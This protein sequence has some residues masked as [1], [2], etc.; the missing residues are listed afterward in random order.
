MC[1]VS[2]GFD[3]AGHF[4]EVRRIVRDGSV[5]ALPAGLSLGLTLFLGGYPRIVGPQVVGDVNDGSWSVVMDVA[6]PPFAIH[7][8]IG[9]TKGRHHSFDLSSFTLVPARQEQRIE[10]E[11]EIGFGMTPYP[12]DYRTPGMVEAQSILQG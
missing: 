12:G 9:G 5:E 1:S 6:L 8:V 7:M 10:A 4:P 11:I 2:G 3:L